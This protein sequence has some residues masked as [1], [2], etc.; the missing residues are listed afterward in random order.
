[1]TDC[2]P[3]TVNDT[4]VTPVGPIG[5]VPLESKR[6]SVAPGRALTTCA[7]NAP[8]SSVTVWR[9]PGIG[10]PAGT[11]TVTHFVWRFPSR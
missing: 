8:S 6:L 1:V 3:Q 9:V 10:E 11:R 5:T 7:S 2:W 4:S